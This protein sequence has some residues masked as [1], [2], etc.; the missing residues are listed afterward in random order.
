MQVNP[1]IS[2]CNGKQ[3]GFNY[4][5]D[6]Y[7]KS[8][9]FF[10]CKYVKDSAAAEDIAENSFIK[11]WE[12]REQMG[13][14]S[15]LRGYLYK[16]VY[17]GCLRW[18]E[19]EKRKEKVYR[20]YKESMDVDESGHVENMIKAETLRRVKEAMEELPSECRKVFMK[21]FVEGKS[22]VEAAAELNVAVSTVKNQKARGIKLLR[23]RLTSLIVFSLWFLVSSFLTYSFLDRCLF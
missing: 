6:T 22:V 4:F 5:F 2:F 16:T 18:I 8:I 10:A 20:V 7:Y 9:Y 13:S 1:L 12:K 23:M 3:E 21:L 17:H 15:G 19:N 14:E 11:L